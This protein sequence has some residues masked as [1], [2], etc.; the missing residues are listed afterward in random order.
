MFWTP[1]FT[2]IEEPNQN[3][4]SNSV[5]AWIRPISLLSLQGASFVYSDNI[6]LYINELL[7]K[8]RIWQHHFHFCISL[9]TLSSCKIYLLLSTAVFFFLK[10]LSILMLIRIS[11][12]RHF[13]AQLFSCNKIKVECTS[14]WIIKYQSS[15]DIG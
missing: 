10:R 7:D 12:F 6:I 2:L 8:N 11:G 14:A 3:I 15:V 13:L 5:R 1:G 9:L 4:L